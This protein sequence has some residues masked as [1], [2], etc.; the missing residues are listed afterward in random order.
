MLPQELVYRP[1]VVLDGFSLPPAVTLALVHMVDVRR[2]VVFECFHDH[3]RLGLRDDTVDSPLKY[4]QRSADLCCVEY[5]GAG[6]IDRGCL[7][8]RTQQ[9]VG[10]AAFELVRL[11]RQMKLVGHAVQ[12]D[13]RGECLGMVDN[14]VQYSKAPSAASHDDCL[15][16]INAAGV[17]Q[18]FRPADGILDIADAPITPQFGS[19][20]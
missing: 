13:T 5:G 16:R 7:R 12:T 3:V 11:G 20:A 14:R 2:S 17:G 18:E 4:R 8:E 6:S 19:W 1:V 15:S 10:V 9:R